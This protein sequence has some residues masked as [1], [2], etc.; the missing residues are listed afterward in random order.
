MN[1]EESYQEVKPAIVAFVPK[2]HPVF[3]PQQPSPEFPP[4]FGTGIIV[5]DG[6]VATNDHV[7]RAIGRLPKPP[8][9]PKDL[10]PV[11]CILLYLIANK[12]VA[13]IKIDVLGVFS[14]EKAEMG[15]SYYGPPKPDIAF[16]RINMKDLPC[17]QVEYDPRKIKEGREVA[18]AGF[19][20]G[21]DTLTAPG[22]LHQITPTLQK[23]II[24]AILPFEC[25]NPHALMINVMTQGG[26][27][28]SPVFL[29]ESGKVIGVLYGG[30]EDIQKT[31]NLKSKDKIQ[32]DPS[33]H[34]HL[35][36]IPTN[37]SYVV[38]SHYIVDLLAKISK[39]ENFKITESTP[40]LKKKIEEG[41]FANRKTGKGLE[42]ERWDASIK[43]K[44]DRKIKQII[45]QEE[46]S[47]PP[48]DQRAG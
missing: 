12:G 2:F 31:V 47:A 29:P 24:S 20:M 19:P 16:V 3:D 13:A 1:L 28:G 30:L 35:Y 45:P 14:I 8:N 37:V 15:T 7:V 34:S 22:Y 18:T 25:D 38:P 40:S 4:I 21:T 27:S 41:N 10:W 17:A 42:Y 26:A 33:T 32:N 43:E 36:K 39:D 9:Y 5:A 44:I 48:L 23:G 46:S 6:I 11:T